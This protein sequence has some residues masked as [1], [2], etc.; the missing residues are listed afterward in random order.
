[1]ANVNKSLIIDKC[2]NGWCNYDGPCLGHTIAIKGTTVTDIYTLEIDGE[3]V[4]TGDDGLLIQYAD[5]IKET[6]E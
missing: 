5:F 3:P 6:L 4:F 2:G 1:M